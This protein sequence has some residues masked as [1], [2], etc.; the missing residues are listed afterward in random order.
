MF[1]VVNEI[2]LYQRN[3]HFWISCRSFA[4][5]DILPEAQCRNKRNVWA[6]R[7]FPK[8]LS[9]VRCETDLFWLK[10][11][12]I[13]VKWFG[14]GDGPFKSEWLPLW[15]RAF[16]QLR[17]GRLGI[18]RGWG[19]SGATSASLS[20]TLNYNLKTVRFAF[21]ATGVCSSR[22]LRT[23]LTS[24]SISARDLIVMPI[25]LTCSIWNQ[26]HEEEG[27]R[28]KGNTYTG[29]MAVRLRAK[30]TC[31]KSLIL[32]LLWCQYKHGDSDKHSQPSAWSALSQLW[33]T[34]QIHQSAGKNARER[35]LMT[36][37]SE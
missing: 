31:L 15:G 37:F 23:L 35:L 32:S 12:E 34:A 2:L 20:Q 24:F 27:A 3:A 13:K 26:K 25:K 4:N 6:E 36:G 5:A 21:W 8:V 9:T 18:G 17:V 1:W 29:N 7:S 14:P 33:L 28:E 16:I 30:Q 19:V 10:N 11:L 22:A